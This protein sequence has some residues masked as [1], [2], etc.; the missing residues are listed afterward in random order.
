MIVTAQKSISYNINHIR[1]NMKETNER[2]VS[3]KEI[4]E[5]V[6][7]YIEE[8]FGDSWGVI[9]LDENNKQVENYE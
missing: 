3:M 1:E 9:L 8:D 7:N 5:V 6:W 2:D 4:L